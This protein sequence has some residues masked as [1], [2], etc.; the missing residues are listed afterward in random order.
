M[1]WGEILNIIQFPMGV[2]PV[3]YFVLLLITTRPYQEDCLPLV[4]NVT[5]KYQ[6]WKD[7]YLSYASGLQ[8]VKS[9]LNSISINWVF[10][11][12]LPMGTIAEINIYAV[13]SY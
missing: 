4:E 2:L 6:G 10:V 1:T 12:L 13:I 5:K 8:L 11:F 3:K 7:K 9:V